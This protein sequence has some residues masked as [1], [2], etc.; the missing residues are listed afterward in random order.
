M[1]NQ[2]IV[3]KKQHSGLRNHKIP[4]HLINNNSDKLLKFRYCKNIYQKIHPNHNH[5]YNHNQNQQNQLTSP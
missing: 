3:I 5:N 1:G 2:Y 4:I